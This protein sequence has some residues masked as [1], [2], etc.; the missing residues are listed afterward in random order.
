M[1]Q[2]GFLSKSIPL[3]VLSLFFVL[4]A[5]GGL[6]QTDEMPPSNSLQPLFELDFHH[7]VP[8]LYT[9]D[10]LKKDW[11]PGAVDRV[12][13]VAEGRVEIAQEVKEANRFLRVHLAA[14]QWGAD[15]GGAQWRT[16]FPRRDEAVG[17][18][19]VRFAPD[20]PFMRG[21]K[22]P[23][24][25]GGTSPTGC[26]GPPSGRDGFSARIMWRA[27]GRAVQYVYHPR[28]PEPCGQ[29]FPWSQGF[30]PGDWHRVRTRVAL[31]RP[32]RND[33][34]IESWLDDRLVLDQT[35]LIFRTTP[36]IGLDHFLVAVFFGGKGP[37]WAPPIAT[38][39]DLD[40]F[41]IWGR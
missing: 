13:G 32:D 18:Y 20:F 28:Q 5:A 14:G 41:V 16:A 24:Q 10:Q 36:E 23:G 11:G 40:D 15:D 22:L 38:F 31:N 33:G 1:N 34:R 26:I 17:S 21:G 8:G 7:H 9:L 37:Q 30:V 39:V 4:K 19:R 12:R 3:L 2:T 29:D 6:G 35:G 25:A 27:G